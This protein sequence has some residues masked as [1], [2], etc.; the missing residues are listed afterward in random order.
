MELI[1]SQRYQTLL[2]A[3]FEGKSK[4]TCQAYQ[5]DLEDFRQYLNVESLDEALA[6]LFYSM[7]SQ[8]TLKAMHYRYTLAERGLKASTINRRFSVLRGISEMAKAKGIIDWSLQVESELVIPETA[9]L[10]EDHREVL[11]KLLKHLEGQK[12]LLRASRDMA[13][14]LLIFD[15][16]LKTSQLEALTMQDLDLHQ[17][18]VMI[19]LSKG[20]KRKRKLSKRS[21]LAL[22]QWVEARGLKAGALFQN[23]DRANK[24]TGL[25][26]TSIYRVIRDL[27]N[28]V[29]LKLT[30]QS[31]RRAVIQKKLKE[32]GGCPVKMQRVAEYASH[33]SIKSLA[34]YQVDSEEDQ[35]LHPS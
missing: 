6:D 22:L 33:Q 5:A 8:A 13:L 21:Q 9:S 3:F 16:G 12:P 28:Q 32:T 20:E 27:G 11:N 2:E 15:L 35:G 1:L 26:G 14:L 7:A 31:L 4:L 23:F 19:S 18:H 25:S 17:G 34:L 29:G 24:A 10:P 30:P